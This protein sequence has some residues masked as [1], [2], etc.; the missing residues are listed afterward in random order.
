M[1]G[2]RLRT[3]SPFRNKTASK[4]WA[5]SNIFVEQQPDGTYVA[6]HSKTVIAVGITQAQTVH[7]AHAKRPGDPVLVERVRMTKG[8]SRDKWRR[9][10]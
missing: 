10:Y 1:R 9:V 2:A 8:G 3:L 5:V 6:I 4:R 7:R